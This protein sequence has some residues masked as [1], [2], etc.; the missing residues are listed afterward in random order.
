MNAAA[1]SSSGRSAGGAPSPETW[2]YTETFL[3]ESD[4]AAR[5]RQQGEGFGAWPVGRGTA[6]LLTVLARLANARAVVEIG[7]GAGVSGLALFAGMQPDGILTSIDVEAEHQNAARQA[8]RE[9][10]IAPQRFRLIAGAALTVL[11]KLSD[12]A[13]DLVLVDGDKLEYAEYVE[14]ALRLLRHGG[15]LAVDNALR[16]GR[17]ADPGNSDDDAIAVREAIEAVRDNTDLTC[18]LLPVGDGLLVAVK[19]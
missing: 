17:V 9:V 1:P 11:P 5:A 8:F 4:T 13:Y 18:S 19:S 14:Q 10:G 15:V 3:P 12:G 16:R 2:D 6:S 7:T